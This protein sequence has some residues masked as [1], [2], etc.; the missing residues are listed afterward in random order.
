MINTL[1]HETQ[2]DANCY[3]AVSGEPIT[4]VFSNN[5][6]ALSGAAISL[7]ISIYASPD[8]GYTETTENGGIA[9]TTH[10]ENAL[11][12]GEEVVSPETITYKVP[13]LAAGTYWLQWDVSPGTMNAWLVVS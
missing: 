10:R 1:P 8:K 5:T 7:N 3:S 12:L 13:P 2:F 11:F 4:I 6:I 9:Y